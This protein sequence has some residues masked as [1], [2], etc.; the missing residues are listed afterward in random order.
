MSDLRYTLIFLTRG[1]DVLMLQRRKPPNQGLWNG[2]GGRIEAGESAEECA[3]REVREETGY[4]LDNLRF[5][6]LVTWEGFEIP[7]GGLYVFSS[8]V[9]AGE[10]GI[11][12]EGT[13]AW[14]AR[15]W[16]FSSPEVVSNIHVFGPHVLAGSHP[17][18]Y[19]FVYR[20]GK[21]LGYEFLPLEERYP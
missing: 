18:R 2:V 13:L 11:T 7:A 8:E 6:G 12:S 3:L 17:Q 20:D 21:I 9:P 1:A 15:D 4:H 5:G 19:H 16:V 10:P 14:K